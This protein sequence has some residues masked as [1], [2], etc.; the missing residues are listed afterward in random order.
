MVQLQRR[1][2]RFR[3]AAGKGAMTKKARTWPGQI[4]VPLILTL[5]LLLTGFAQ[6]QSTRQALQSTLTARRMAQPADAAPDALYDFYLRRDFQPAWSGTGRAEQA[7]AVVMQTLARSDE[8]GLQPADYEATAK[9]WAEPPPQAVA[10]AAYDLSLTEE[11][12]LY[13]RHV[14]LGR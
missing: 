10:A 9:Q 7:G 8:Q 12:L 4:P 5:L 2:R 11:L 6:A 13:A 3:M 14:R 1:R